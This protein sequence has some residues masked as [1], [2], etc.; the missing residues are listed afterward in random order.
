[1]A[2]DPICGMDVDESTAS[3]TSVYKG[4]KYFFCAPGCKKTFDSDPEKYLKSGPV[5][6]M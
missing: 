3:V 6:H 2:Q 5:G 1:M 4:Q